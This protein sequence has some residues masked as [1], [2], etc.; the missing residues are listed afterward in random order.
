M[1][2]FLFI[3]HENENMGVEYLS[4]SL[5]RNNYTIELLFFPY[6]T[7]D[8]VENEAIVEKINTYKPDIVCFSPFS[9]QYPW[10]ISKADFVKKE[11]PKLFTLFGGVHVNSVPSIV[12]E[13]ECIDGI[14]VGEADRTIVEFA[15]N[16]EVGDISPTPSLWYRKDGKI[17]K[18]SMA[19]LEQDLDSLP[20]PDKEIF[21]NSPFAPGP[22]MFA[23]TALGSRGCPFACTYCS[24]NVFSRLYAGQ[25]RLRYRS[26][27]NFVEELEQNKKKFNYKRIEFADDVL[28]I[29]ISRLRQLMEL[30]KEKVNVP[31]ACFFH[32]KLVSEEVVKLLSD[33]GCTWFKLG[34]QSANEEYRKKFLNRF[35]T[36]ENILEVSR[37]CRRYGLKFSFDHILHLPGETKEHLI[38]AV[39]FYNECRPTIIN[40]WDLM[41]L[42][43]TDIIKYGLEY[44]TISD[45]DLPQINKGTHNLSKLNMIPWYSNT[46]KSINYSAFMLLFMLIGVIPSWFIKFLMKKKFYE[47]RFQIPNIILVPVKI[48]SKLRAGQGYLYLSS[49]IGAFFRRWQALKRAIIKAWKKLYSFSL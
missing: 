5:K 27:E 42:P 35:E 6:T 29:D 19:P 16:Y 38:E 14:I 8:K 43:A 25:K 3:Q 39:N 48:A 18:N 21:Y 30:Y 36:N 46:N 20:F 49:V 44:K 7:N 24:N 40:F 32:P 28:A 33:G 1:L 10:A 34:V 41:Y 45:N 22:R 9:Y 15:K 31:F 23:Y 47:I 37:L 12:M 13:D 4:A 11:F 17:I 2:K 26:P